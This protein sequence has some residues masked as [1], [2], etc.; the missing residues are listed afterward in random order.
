M[1]L[2]VFERLVPCVREA[3]PIFVAA[4]QVEGLLAIVLAYRQ[5][6]GW[7]EEFSRNDLL[8]VSGGNMAIDNR[9]VTHDPRTTDD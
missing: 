9:R 5:S 2:R 6:S 3:N 7:A 4:E 8:R 1:P